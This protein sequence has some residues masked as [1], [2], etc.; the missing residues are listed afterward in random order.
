MSTSPGGTSS[1]GTENFPTL[2]A[3]RPSGGNSNGSS[4]SGGSMAS[5]GRSQARP[6]TASGGWAS[7]SR[8][9]VVDNTIQAREA[10]RNRRMAELK[11]QNKKV[12]AQLKEALKGDDAALHSVRQICGL[13]QSG[14][15][16]ARA[17][18]DIFNQYN[19]LYLLPDVAELCP[20]Q[21]SGE[22]LLNASIEAQSSK[23]NSFRSK[24]LSQSSQQQPIRIAS[25]ARQS[26]PAST[27]SQP[28]LKERNAEVMQKLKDGCRG[29]TVS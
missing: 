23:P 24:I 25:V 19:I 6:A 2:G 21:E 26:R 1:F 16:S 13:Y 9:Q 29:I 17:V 7:T 27:I 4:S 18:V 15:E 10:E 8:P 20:S 5:A 11:E 3:S 28:S 22:A 14:N 12:A